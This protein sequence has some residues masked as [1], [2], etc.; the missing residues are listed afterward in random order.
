M[1]CGVDG[2]D[3]LKRSLVRLEVLALRDSRAAGVVA[4][5]GTSRRV[6][7]NPVADGGTASVDENGSTLIDGTELGATWVEAVGSGV[8]EREMEPVM[9]RQVSFSTFLFERGGMMVWVS[10]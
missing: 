4:V 1:G 6:E 10:A 3:C 2:R 8:G 7:G 5:L 9:S